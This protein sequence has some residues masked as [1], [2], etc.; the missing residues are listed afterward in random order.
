MEEKQH[1]LGKLNSTAKEHKND[2]YYTPKNVVDKIAEM[3]GLNFVY[4]PATDIWNAERLGIEKYDT[5]ETNGLEQDWNEKAQGGDIWINPPFTLKKEFIKKAAELIR[6]GYKGKIAIIVPDKSITN[7]H[8][9]DDLHNIDKALVIPGGRVNYIN[10]DK[11]PTK[12]NFFGS[13]IWVLGAETNIVHLD[14]KEI[15]VGE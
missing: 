6:N 4:D 3:F 11:E 7:K 15:P 14:K 13:V 5:I 2:E 10:K 1:Q 8:I 9:Y 12:G